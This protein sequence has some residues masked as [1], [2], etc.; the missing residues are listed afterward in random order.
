MKR[1]F[2]AIIIVPL[3]EE[4]DNVVSLFEFTDDLS[5]DNQMMFAVAIQSKPPRERIHEKHN[6][7]YCAGLRCFIYRNLL[8][9]AE[10]F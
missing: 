5:T 9:S 2:D 1:Y 7:L 6:V 8:F 10:K 3:E 4:F